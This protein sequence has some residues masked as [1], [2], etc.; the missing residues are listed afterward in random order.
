MP[1]NENAWNSN[2]QGIKENVNQ[3]N[4]TSEA[5]DCMGQLRKT[6]ARWWTVWA[7]VAEFETASELTVDYG[8]GCQGGRNTQ[9][10]TRVHW[11]VH[12]RLAGKLHCS[13]SGPSPTVSR[14]AQ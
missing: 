14:A 10:H 6:E 5:E 11:K 3:N 7:K 8:G 9:S 4:Q 2:N 12:W 13:L 1:E